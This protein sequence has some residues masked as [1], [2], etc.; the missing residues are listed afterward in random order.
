MGLQ[1]DILEEDETE[2]D[3]ADIL[4]PSPILEQ[5]SASTRTARSTHT[6]EEVGKRLKIVLRRLS[7]TVRPYFFTPSPLVELKTIGQNIVSCFQPKHH[8]DDD[9]T[10]VVNDGTKSGLDLLA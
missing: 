9:P 1:S 4:P 2:I 8:Q 5:S 3:I 7:W 10:P 6:L